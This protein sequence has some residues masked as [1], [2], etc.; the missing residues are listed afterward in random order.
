F[1][2]VGLALELDEDA[3]AVERTRDLER[4]P[5]AFRDRKTRFVRLLGPLTIAAYAVDRSDPAKQ[6]GGIGGR[7][8]DGQGCERRL[9]VSQRRIPVAGALCRARRRNPLR[10]RHACGLVRDHAVAREVVELR[11]HGLVLEV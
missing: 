2:E 7:T 6:I 1:G 8:T 5:C 10:Y 3:E 11:T 4:Q 9:V